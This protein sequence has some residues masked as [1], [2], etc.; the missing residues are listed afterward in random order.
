[1]L[2]GVF[3]IGVM[4]ER[5][6]PGGLDAMSRMARNIC[7]CR[8]GDALIRVAPL[9]G[10]EKPNWFWILYALSPETYFKDYRLGLKGLILTVSP[11]F[12]ARQNVRSSQWA[13]AVSAFRH[14]TGQWP[15][16]RKELETWLEIGL[17]EDIYSGKGPVFHPGDPPEIFSIGPDQIPGNA[18]DIH[19]IPRDDAVR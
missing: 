12:G 3:L 11:D 9:L 6:P 4:V 2:T 5:I 16:S 7:W 19:F 13:I 15:S 14:G 8:G 1:M 18:D 17:P 10:V